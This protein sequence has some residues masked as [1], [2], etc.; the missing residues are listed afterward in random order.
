M[1]QIKVHGHLGC[2]CI[3]GSVDEQH[4]QRRLCGR[5]AH[6]AVRR[7]DVAKAVDEWAGA[8]HLGGESW[9]A[10]P[11]VQ[12]AAWR[13]VR[14]QHVHSVGN[15]AIACCKLVAIALEAERVVVINLRGRQRHPRRAVK[16]DAAH[17]HLRI[18]Q[19]DH[20]VARRKRRL[21]RCTLVGRCA[22]QRHLVVA[23]DDDAVRGL[24]RAKPADKVG[25]L[26]LGAVLGEIAAANE[27][28]HLGWQR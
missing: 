22:A 7:V 28:V 1:L 4:G 13:C 11:I 12:G 5:L 10:E 17:L 24:L 19:I 8:C 9:R 14:E 6:M 27:H 26:G 21:Q 2:D 3:D 20:A 23:A 25:N 16:A 18:L 15:G